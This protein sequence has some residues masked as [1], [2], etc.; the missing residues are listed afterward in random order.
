MLSLLRDS[1]GK[2]AAL[3]AKHVR[4]CH[5]CPS[6][7]TMSGSPCSNLG[8]NMD[9]LT[10]NGIVSVLSAVVS[11]FSLTP[12]FIISTGMPIPML[13]GCLR[14]AGYALPTGSLNVLSVLF[15]D[16]GDPADGAISMESN[17]HVPC[18]NMNGLNHK[19]HSD[20]RE[21]LELART[22]VRSIT[23]VIPYP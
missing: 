6:P 23:T 5:P 7:R 3:Y 12:V 4:T 8:T 21:V 1:G 17:S 11:L 9:D 15:C 18:R 13:T 22:S 10:E 19:L 14:T 16:I 2:L 20:R